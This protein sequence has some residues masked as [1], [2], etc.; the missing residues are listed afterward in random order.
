MELNETGHKILF[1]DKRRRLQLFN[2]DTQTKSSLLSYSTYVQV[3]VYFFFLFSFV[4]IPPLLL[5]N[6][7]VPLLFL[8]SFQNPIALNPE[9]H[10]RWQWVPNSD[11]VIAQSHQNLCIWYNIDAPERVTTFPLK[12]EITDIERANGRTD[13][14]VP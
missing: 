2:I 13:V 11:V 8:I 3:G 14:R 10:L 9:S 12:G 1:R 4:V 7:L 5:H 6:L